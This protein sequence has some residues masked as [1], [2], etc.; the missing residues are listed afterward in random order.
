MF[1]DSASSNDVLPNISVSAW[2]NIAVD[3][4]RKLCIEFDSFENV[5]CETSIVAA[6]VSYLSIYESESCIYVCMLDKF[7][8]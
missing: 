1:P 5:E 6:A 3:A 2:L 7:Y 4:D 8:R